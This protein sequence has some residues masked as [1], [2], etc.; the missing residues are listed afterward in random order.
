M[1]F[2]WNLVQIRQTLRESVSRRTSCSTRWSWTWTWRRRGWTIISTLR[3]ENHNKFSN[4]YL[5]LRIW[6]HPLIITRIRRLEKKI[7]KCI[8][9]PSRLNQPGRLTRDV[10][11][12]LI[13]TLYPGPGPTLYQPRSTTTR[14]TCRTSSWRSW[15]V[16]SSSQGQGLASM[17]SL[18]KN[19]PNKLFRSQWFFPR[20][21][22]WLMPS[23][24]IFFKIL[25]SQTGVV[26][27]T[28]VTYTWSLVVW[29][30]RK[31]KDN[32]GSSRGHR[33]QLL[34]LQHQRQQLD[35]QVR[36]GGG[37]A[38]AS[39]VC[40]GEAVSTLHHLHWRDW[41]SAEWEIRG[42]TRGVPETQDWVPPGVWW[43]ARN[44]WR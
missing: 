3:T 8:L 16:R 27:W 43:S 19:K 44:C 40:R 7:R 12:A 21:G 26:H 29:S 30:S 39:I 42:W 25:F 37:E 2:C 17:I 9:D 22:D 20:S 1:V 24:L 36:G 18:D 35:Q 34:V 28:E 6:S 15:W 10:C 38:G 4:I 14:S 13:I 23:N 41:Q 32:V 5:F 11:Q 31:W 33:V